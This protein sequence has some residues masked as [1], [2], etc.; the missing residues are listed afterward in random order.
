MSGGGGRSGVTVTAWR[1]SPTAVRS[2]PNK[3]QETNS[4]IQSRHW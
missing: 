2:Y 4:G 1:T 3:I